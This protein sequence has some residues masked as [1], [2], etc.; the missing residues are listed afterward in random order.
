MRVLFHGADWASGADT[1]Q[2]ELNAG[3]CSVVLQMFQ[4]CGECVVLW[5]W[6]LSSLNGVAYSVQVF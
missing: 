3:E 5:L 2:L 4:A 6:C 1:E